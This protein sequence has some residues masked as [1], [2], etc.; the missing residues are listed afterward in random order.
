MKK[1]K[2]TKEQRFFEISLWIIILLVLSYVLIVNGLY[3][4]L[5]DR[6]LFGDM[7]GGLGAL[8]SGFAF[9]GLIYTIILQREDLKLTRKELAKTAEAQQKSE[10]ALR[11]QIKS[12]EKTAEL[13]GLNSILQ[14]LGSELV[15]STTGIMGHDATRRDWAR[16]EAK[17]V[18][19][20]IEE[21]ISTK[22]K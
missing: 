21:R 8:F 4:K 7:F 19:D 11:E 13:N 2:K 3:P 16:N 5:E 17:I 18:R 1:N 6:A 20:K 10:E 9:M 12:M 14:Y 22:N 15:A